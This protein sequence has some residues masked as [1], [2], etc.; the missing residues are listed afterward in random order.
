MSIN[1]LGPIVSKP[2]PLGVA[3]TVRTA[4]E[5]K[6]RTSTPLQSEVQAPEGVNPALWHILTDE[7]RVFFVQQLSLGPVT[8]SPKARSG[9]SGQQGAP[10]GQRIDVRA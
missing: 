3:H 5:S 2:E 7:E 10:R 8:Y 9:M 1:G 6:G 4:T